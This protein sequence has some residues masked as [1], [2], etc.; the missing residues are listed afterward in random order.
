MKVY[1]YARLN[2]QREI[3]KNF[4]I[5][6]Q[7]EIIQKYAKTHGMKLKKVFSDIEETS[8]SLELPNLKKIIQ[9]AEKN[10]LDVLIVA[11]LDRVTRSIRPFHQ[12]I[13]KVCQT[14]GVT[15]ISIEEDINTSTNEGRSV[16]QVIDIIAK[17]DSKMISDRTKE[18]I[19]RK[20]TIGERVGHAPFGFVYE[21]KKLVPFV[22]E[23]KIAFLIKEK[24]NDEGLSYHKIAKYLNR[25]RIPSKRG[26][27]WYAETIKTIYENPLYNDPLL[28]DL[29][30]S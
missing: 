23:L 17:W 4:S 5:K 12:F 10:E 19:E 18:L 29:A 11:R 7:S 14:N 30:N 6:K 15:F 28:L 8:V 9:L 13:Q 20:R 2:K 26:G 1:G 21:Q 27:S 24:R 25:S 22:P 3:P 16:L